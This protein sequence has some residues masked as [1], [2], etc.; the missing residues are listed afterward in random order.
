MIGQIDVAIG[1]LDQRDVG[2]KPR[3]VERI[4][5]FKLIGREVGGDLIFADRVVQG[6]NGDVIGL[7]AVDGQIVE[8]RR[9]ARAADFAQ[10]DESALPIGDQHPRRASGRRCDLDAQQRR[11]G[12]GDKLKVIET[13]FEREGGG[14]GTGV[15]A[16]RRVDRRRHLLITA[17]HQQIVVAHR[18]A[19]AGDDQVVRDVRVQRRD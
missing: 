15:S 10:T 3:I 9:G 8:H 13:V 12:G 2:L 11:A 7:S 6:E 17:G 14:D 18:V 19:F 16:G 5:Q 1:L 4:R